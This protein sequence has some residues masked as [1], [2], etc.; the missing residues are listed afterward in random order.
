MDD[1]L[2]LGIDIGSSSTKGLLV[3]I[4]G[5]ILSSH[6]IRHSFNQPEA[7]WAEQNPDETWWPETVEIIRACIDKARIDAARIKGIAVTGMVPNL[8]PIDKNGKIVRPAIF[9]RDNRASEE[10]AFLNEK[11]GLNFN[12]QDMLPK[13]YWIKNNEPENYAKISMVLNTHSY[14]IYKLTGKYNIDCDTADLFGEIYN[15]ATLSWKNDLV[16]KIGLNREALPPVY[17][18]TDAVGTVTDEVCAMTG[19]KNTTP[20]FAGNG[21]SLMSM[22]GSSVVG[23]NDAMIYLGTAATLIATDADMEEIV[24]GST[25]NSGHI[26]FLGNVLTG[27]EYLKWFKEKL[28]LQG[29]VLSF[30]ELDTL[31]GK[32][33]P[34]ANGLISLPHLEGQRT[35]V[36][37]PS[38]S[39]GIV[40]INSKHTGVHIYRA[41]LESIAYAL[42][43]STLGKTHMLK[44]LVVSG[45]AAASRSLR[46]ILADVF[47]M[48][49]EY[50]PKSGAALGIAYFAGYSLGLF[51]DFKTIRRGWLSQMEITQPAPGN[52]EQYKKCFDAYKRINE[53][54]SP[55]YP[56]LCDKKREFKQ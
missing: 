2:L 26:H 18:Q 14:L 21:D 49:V 40:G 47:N 15:P 45:G 22:I 50:N 41:I 5:D 43:D 8:C 48:P 19:L 28:Q 17:R 35:P 37:N 20:V 46:Q 51:N 30:E 6:S 25:F 29:D 13:W 55:I 38:A 10:C 23:A 12:L 7:G 39:G 11:Y 36:Y 53:A 16:D 56:L 33:E 24:S 1:G 44:R 42:L 3:N 27:A 52:A 31:A 9:Y 34:G 4:K 32:I 54:L